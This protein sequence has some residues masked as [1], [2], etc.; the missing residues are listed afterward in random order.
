MATYRAGIIGTGWIA[1]SH[2]RGWKAAE[3]VEFAVIADTNDE[4]RQEFGDLFGVAPESRYADFREMLDREHLDIVSVCTWHPQHAEMT[5]AAAARKPRVILSEKPMALGLGEA[6]AMLVACQRNKVKLAI[7]H[8]TRFALGAIEARRLIATGAIGQPVRLWAAVAG[9]LLNNGTHLIDLQRYLLG[10]PKTEWVLGNVE[11]KT[12]RY[13]RATAIEDACAGIIQYAG[14]AQGT[15]ESDLAEQSPGGC[16]VVG[17]EGM[18]EVS[19]NVVRL[20][21]AETAGWRKVMDGPE[22][23]ASVDQARGIVDWIEGR[24]ED[25]R[26]DGLKARATLEIMMAI[27]ESARRHEVV[28]MPLLT[29]SNPL[30]LMIESGQL[31]PERPG[32]YDIR[33]RLVRGE[34]MSWL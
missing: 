10:D 8:Q 15:I 33:S 24:V 34:G 25:Y 30:D 29:R 9:G 22:S 6:D 5:I 27:Y 31:P 20:F 4:A 11:R 12:D 2:A 32:R 13:E 26:S 21:N 28:R 18:L 23:D 1:E 3:G 17:T 14:G 7:G 19:R 16:V